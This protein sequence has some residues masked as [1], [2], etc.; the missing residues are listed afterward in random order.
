LEAWRAMTFLRTASKSPSIMAQPEVRA[1]L[2]IAEA[3]MLA[4]LRELTRVGG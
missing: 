2:A 1:A 4:L 3:G